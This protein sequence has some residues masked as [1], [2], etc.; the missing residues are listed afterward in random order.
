MT[1]HC[2][3][4]NVK[5]PVNSSCLYTIASSLQSGKPPT[6]SWWVNPAAFHIFKYL[7]TVSFSSHLEWMERKLTETWLIFEMWL[8]GMLEDHQKVPHWW[9]GSNSGYCFRYHYR[10][11]KIEIKTGA[12]WI[13]LEAPRKS[14]L[15]ASVGLICS[16]SVFTLCSLWMGPRCHPKSRPV[17]RLWPTLKSHFCLIISWKTQLSNTII[18][19]IYGGLG[20]PQMNFWGDIIQSIACN[21]QI[22]LT[23]QDFIDEFSC[24]F[25]IRKLF[26]SYHHE[27]NSNIMEFK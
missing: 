7:N 21:Q 10:V 16:F 20:L 17:S 3:G 6:F 24:N 18:F 22:V 23:Y 13:H 12:S 9:S 11:Q 25:E 19:K 2:V 1:L 8:I 4:S 26:Y 27:L 15:Q 5:G 14:P